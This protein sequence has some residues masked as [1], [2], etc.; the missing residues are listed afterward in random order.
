[1]LCAVRRLILLPLLA[2]CAAPPADLVLRGG[3]IVTMDPERPAGTALAARGGML[4]AVGSDTDVAGLIGP[5]T[6]VIELHGRTACPGFFDAHL[7]LPGL[8]QAARLVDLVG[9]RSEAE[10]VAR[11]AARAARTPPGNWITGRGW[12][13]NDWE[14]QDFPTH[15]ALSAALPDRP[16][17]LKRIDGHALLANAA[18]MERAGISAATPDPD[19]GRIVRDAAG[20]P[21]GVFVDNATALIE[22]VVPEFSREELV[23]GLPLVIEDLHRRGITA[24]TDTGVSLATAQLYAELAR[25]GRLPSADL[26]GQGRVAVRAAKVYADGAL[27]SRGAALL[28]PYDDDP[29]N[30]GLLLTPPEEI[31]ALAERCLRAG[32]QL[33][34]HAI[35]DRGNRVT[36]DAYEAALAAVPPLERAVP[37][38]R[39]RIEHA[40]VL[41]QEDV[42]RFAQLGVI[43]SMQALHQTSDMPWAE[44]RLGPVRVAG[45]YAWRWLLDSGARLCGGSDAPVETPDPLLGFRANVT[46]ADAQGQPPGGWHPEQRLTRDEALASITSWAAFAC[47]EEERLGSLRPGLAADIVVLSDDLLTLPEERLADLRVELTIFDGR[48][49]FAR[50]APP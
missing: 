42:P 33:G 18:A 48:V 37:E 34:T 31:E 29:G 4:V 22:R 39:F 8:A 21:T 13:Q 43:A 11:A 45:A 15:V 50:D 32:W 30:S 40:Q 5:G 12:D 6:E 26:T 49:V 20:A 35:G 16:A 47:F 36:L 44:A 46:R 38:P 10:V 9:T 24:V 3:R 14:R 27:G 28:A 19:G 41:A 7:H 23:A 17:V 2:A 25:A 1:M